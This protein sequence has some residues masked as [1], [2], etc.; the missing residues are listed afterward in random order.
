SGPLFIIT[1][2]LLLLVRG[3]TKQMM[4]DQHH[5][6]QAPPPTTQGFKRA[7]AHCIRGIIA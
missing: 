4:G 7:M 6:P 1:P 2:H 3:L 5:L